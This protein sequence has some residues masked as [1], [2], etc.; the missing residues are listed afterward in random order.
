M[1]NVNLSHHFDFQALTSR[2]SIYVYTLFKIQMSLDEHEVMLVATTPVPR[3]LY[4][5]PNKAHI[6][7]PQH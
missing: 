3:S 6:P 5:F 7:V 1:V 2:F 4:P